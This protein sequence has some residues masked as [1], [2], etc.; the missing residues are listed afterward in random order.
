MAIKIFENLTVIEFASV[1][2]GPLTGSFLAELGAKVIKIENKRTGGDGTRKW[3]LANE[4]TNAAIGS[5]Y[6]ACN[7]GKESWQLDLTDSED[8]ERVLQLL[9][10][11]DIVLSNFKNTAAKKFRLD[12]ENVKQIVPNIIYTQLSGYEFDNNRPAYD[13]VL[14]AES[15]FLYLNG[16]KNEMPIKIPFAFIDV[17]A[18]HQM[19]E[20]ILVAL[21]KKTQTGEGSLVCVS[22]LQAAVSALINQASNYLM[23]DNIPERMGSQHPN[24]APYGD[25][26]TCKDRQLIL[27]AVGTEI[28]F[29]QLCKVLSIENLNSDNRFNSNQKRVTNRVELLPVLE[30][31]IQQKSA[32]EWMYLF[33]ANEVPAGIVKNMQQVFE[34]PLAQKMIK[35]ETIEGV[36]TKRVSTIAFEITKNH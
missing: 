32:N 9:S 25:L 12:Y 29:N 4:P 11:A 5:Y 26:F 10:K 6:A 20:G 28:Q 2:A 7:Y 30:K 19:R 23:N 8:F 13:A 1:L 27:L 15:G 21:L 3:K 36:E 18:S 16:N 22:M 34:H 35:T 14:Q 24:I 17:L 33:E 31:R